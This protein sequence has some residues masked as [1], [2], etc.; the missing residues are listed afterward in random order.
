MTHLYP[1]SQI[2]VTILILQQDGAVMS[3]AINATTLALVHAGISL[4]S[5]VSSVTISCLHDTPFLDPCG[6]E[7]IDLPT[8]TVACLAPPTDPDPEEDKNGKVTLINMETRLSIDRFQGMLKLGAQACAVISAEMDD[9]IRAWAEETQDRMTGGGH[10][11]VAP[12]AEIE[13]LM[14]ED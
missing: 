1:R 3:A 14:D 4:S 2:D 6:P 10:A 7:E 8:V 13:D 12:R 9:V 5:P 11:S